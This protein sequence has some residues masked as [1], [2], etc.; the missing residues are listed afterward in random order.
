[1]FDNDGVFLKIH[2]KIKAKNAFLIVAMPGVALIGKMVGDQMIK[3]LKAEPLATLYSYSL[4]AIAPSLPS[5]ELKTFSI[6]LYHS[7]T[8][9]NDFIIATG[10]SQPLTQEGLYS[11]SNKIL[12]FFSSLG[13]KTVIGIGASASNEV[14]KQR[15]IFAYSTDKKNLEGLAKKGAVKNT[16]YIQVFGM[17]G[18]APAM[19]PLYNL[20]GACLLSEV[21]PQPMDVVGAVKMLEFIGEY[22]NEK[23]STKELEKEG[24][25][26]SKFFESLQTPPPVNELQQSHINPNLSYIH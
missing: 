10:D 22:F 7:K 3:D 13:G 18:I 1:M 4:P 25:K 15:R 11:V 14:S 6:E 5:G 24:L 16:A 9:K 20:N 17:A 8:K 12:S 21:L 2:K 23:L 26:V 19:A